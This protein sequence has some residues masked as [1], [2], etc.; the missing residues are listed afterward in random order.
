MYFNISY[1]SQRH[2]ALLI[3]L[4]TVEHLADSY[5]KYCK[6]LWTSVLA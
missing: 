6:L 1:D 3:T 2:I 4:K 5:G